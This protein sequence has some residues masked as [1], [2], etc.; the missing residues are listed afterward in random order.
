MCDAWLDVRSGRIKEIGG[1]RCISQSV[2]LNWVDRQNT[3]G[4]DR[5]EGR[6]QCRRLRAISYVRTRVPLTHLLSPRSLSAAYT[7]TPTICYNRGLA[8]THLYLSTLACGASA[9]TSSSDTRHD[10]TR[11]KRNRVRSRSASERKHTRALNYGV[12]EHPFPGHRIPR[13][14]TR[15]IRAPMIDPPWATS[16]PLA[17]LSLIVIILSRC[18]SLS[19]SRKHSVWRLYGARPRMP[20]HYSPSDSLINHFI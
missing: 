5:A 4:S 19:F 16:I 10:S 14:P 17:F 20:Y 2:G 3:R 11:R 1:Y 18:L 12:R 9:P 15:L 8:R 13:I 7:Y 6:R